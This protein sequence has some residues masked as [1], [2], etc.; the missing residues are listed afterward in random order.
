MPTR[1]ESEVLS[2]ERAP[3]LTPADECIAPVADEVAAELDAGHDAAQ[4][5]TDGAPEA[6]FGLLGR[7]LGHSFSPKIHAL[8]GST[9][10]A[11]F[12]R[13]PQEVAAFLREGAWRGL[14]V[15]IPYKRRA[16]ELA[17]EVGEVARELGAVNT[18]VKRPDGTIYAD[19]T[20]VFGF[21]W[22]L[23]R[24][25]ERTFGADPKAVLAGKVALILGSGG[26]QEAVRKVLGD[27][28]AMVVV[29]S[30]RGPETYRTLAKRHADAFLIVNTTPVGMYPDCP[31]SPL[32]KGTL[33]ELPELKGVIDIVYNPLRT[34]LI[35]EAER[36]GI[37]SEG[38]LGMLVAQAFASSEAFQGRP[39]DPA[40]IER[41]LGR[42]VKETQDIY[43]IGM[44]GAGKTGAARRLAHL[45]GRPFVDLDDTFEVTF[46]C[47]AA[48]FIR[49]HGEEAFRREET[50]ILEDV[51][52]GQGLVVA[53]GGGVVVKEE[54]FSLLRQN[55]YV[56]MLNRPLEE[57]SMADRPLSAA[58]GLET[59]AEERMGLYRSWAD[60][61]IACTGSAEGDALL[62]R[63]LLDLSHEPPQHIHNPR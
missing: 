46:E 31:K 9:P 35:L 51:S 58:K 27:A 61:E 4:A 10:Y 6:R 24:F 38:G 32:E 49:A 21:S 13:E 28:G 3:G 7:T 18:L 1:K 54:N 19:N 59:L 57:L 14:N 15:T 40:L 43:F 37:A 2:L 62:V 36:L 41:I 39:L 48:E 63:E 8:L 22:L 16:F 12:E 42:L 45:V 47:S 25:T 17:D 30:R 52:R 20:D 60:L 53:C 26:A 34:A 50:K 55:G 29:I 44:P 33:E 5:A 56:V 23:E 11:L